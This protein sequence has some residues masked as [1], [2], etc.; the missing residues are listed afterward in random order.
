MA[1]EEQRLARLKREA[2]VE[3][4]RCLPGDG[5]AKRP[6]KAG[7]QDVGFV[8]VDRFHYA[9]VG[10]LEAGAKAF[11][12][13]C[14]FRKEKSAIRE[15]TQLIRRYLPNHLFP[16]PAAQGATQGQG[17]PG[18]SAAA[19]DATAGAQEQPPAEAEAGAA[20]SDPPEGTSG[21]TGAG[22]KEP[23]AASSNGKGGGEESE[24]DGSDDEDLGGSERVEGSAPPAAPCA[25]GMV[26]VGCRGVAVMRLSAAA[27]A[28][29]D[30]VQVVGSLLA[31]VEAGRLRSPTYVQR[32]IPLDATCASTGPAIARAVATAAEAHRRRQA[33]AGLEAAAASDAAANATAA[34]AAVAVEPF[35]FSVVYRNRQT[36]TVGPKD[37]GAAKASTAASTAA[38]AAA[39]AIG[40]DGGEAAA[41]DG[42]AGQAGAATEGQGGGREEEEVLQDRGRI[43]AAVA[44]GVNQVFGQAAKVDLKRPQVVVMVE[45]LP[46]AGRFLLGL[47][48]L[49]P[50][51]V[52]VKGRV[53]V[54]ALVKNAPKEG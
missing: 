52:V 6:R 34:A 27:G 38:A 31:D 4:R 7:A 23:S 30:P 40:S 10:E 29:V 35:T 45:V 18:T 51:L 25:L 54:R 3:M 44:A 5:G 50:S 37:G 32:I 1:S 24:D 22:A 48:L 20:D 2:E 33:G 17:G 21:A 19:P 41:A 39:P 11:V 26:K 8:H 15:A 16:T 43:I 42:A 28:C 36:E 49:G 14:N 47:S 12:L 46:V 13:T 9:V 53:S